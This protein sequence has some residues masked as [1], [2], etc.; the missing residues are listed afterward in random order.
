VQTE[1]DKLRECL[2][3]MLERQKQKL[4]DLFASELFAS[5]QVLEKK[6]R[7]N[8]LLASERKKLDAIVTLFT[9][10]KGQA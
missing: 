9:R 4:D 7:L 8:D 1:Q 3:A 6:Q 2:D 5:E 10:T